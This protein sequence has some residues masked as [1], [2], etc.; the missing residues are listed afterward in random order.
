[1]VSS[2]ESSS[3]WISSSANPFVSLGRDYIPRHRLADGKWGGWC[4]GM[5][6]GEHER[7][8][9]TLKVTSC[10]TTITTPRSSCSPLRRLLKLHTSRGIWSQ[11]TQRWLDSFFAGQRPQD[12]THVLQRERLQ[13]THATQSD[14]IQGRQGWNDLSARSPTWASNRIW[15]LSRHPTWLKES[16]VMIASS[17][18]TVDRR[19]RCSTRK[20]RRRRRWCWGWSARIAKPSRNWRWNDVNISSWGTLHFAW[21]GFGAWCNANAWGSAAATRR[22]RV[23]HW[24][25]RWM[26]RYLGCNYE[27]DEQHGNIDRVIRP[28]P[29]SRLSGIFAT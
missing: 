16:G 26:G 25:F 22:R 3:G 17:R 1:M 11:V 2:L 9:H 4:P 27:A 21:E 6:Y 24:C 20:P 7:L 23:R 29:V 14:P 15:W 13:E 12:P 18:D 10:F 5:G 28:G 19:S 8:L